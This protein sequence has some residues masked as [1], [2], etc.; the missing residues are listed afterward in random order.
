[1]IDTIIFDLD[2]TLMD[3]SSYVLSG[4]KVVSNY[5]SGKYKINERE[6]FDKLRS[7]FYENGRNGIFDYILENYGIEKKPEI[8][9]MIEVYRSHKPS[10]LFYD[11][12]S[13]LLDYL[14]NRKIKIGILTDGLPLMQKNKVMALGLDQYVDEV[15]FSWEIDCKKPSEDGVLYILKKLGSSIENSLMVGDNPVNDIEPA[16]NLGM[17]AIRVVKGRFSKVKNKENYKPDYESE[18]LKDIFEKVKSY[19]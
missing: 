12:V 13:E 15:V 19:V 7:F 3:E 4:M 8:P 1:M 5:L 14:R 2:E 17:K 9:L 6:V 10:L 18:D 11:G 16:M